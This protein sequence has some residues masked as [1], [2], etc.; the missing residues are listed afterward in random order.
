[1]L[2]EERPFR[3]EQ[4]V[5]KSTEASNGQMQQHIQNKLVQLRAKIFFISYQKINM[6]WRK[7]TWEKISRKSNI[8]QKT[9]SIQF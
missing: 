6:I 3:K 8:S 9:I 5:R 1:M 7:L 2:P 4:Y